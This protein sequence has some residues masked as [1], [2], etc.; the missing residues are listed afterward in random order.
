MFIWIEKRYWLITK[1]KISIST[2][3]G[4]H[5]LQFENKEFL[6]LRR[7]STKEIPYLLETTLNFPVKSAR[8]LILSLTGFSNAH[9]IF[10]NGP[11]LKLTKHHGNGFWYCWNKTFHFNDDQIEFDRP[12][13]QPSNM[14]AL[15]GIWSRYGAP[16]KVVIPNPTLIGGFIPNVV[17]RKTNE[18]DWPQILPMELQQTLQEDLGTDSVSL[19]LMISLLSL[20]T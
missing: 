17:R 10:E 18:I 9:L 2:F 19:C 15:K 12:L 1:S 5:K 20:L 8:D 16:I 3:T 4:Y 14:K 6:L 13:D 11:E 7:I